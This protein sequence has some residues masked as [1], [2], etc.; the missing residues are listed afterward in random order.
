MSLSSEQ[1]RDNPSEQSNPFVR[2]YAFVEGEES[3]AQVFLISWRG[4]FSLHL[5][6][7]GE[8]ICPA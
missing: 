3:M 2:L 1:H 4:M 7:T 6:I 5:Q 8:V